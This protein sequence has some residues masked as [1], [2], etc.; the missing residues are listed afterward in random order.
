MA[1]CLFAFLVAVAIVAAF[2]SPDL[3]FG[4]TKCTGAYFLVPSRLPSP[5]EERLIHRRVILRSMLPVPYIY[6]LVERE[7]G[8]ANFL[9]EQVD[10]SFSNS[11]IG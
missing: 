5:L 4:D 11:L 2:A 6:T 8:G 1:L 7:Q 9:V 10:V 3:G